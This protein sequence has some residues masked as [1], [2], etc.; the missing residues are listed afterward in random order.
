MTQGIDQLYFQYT[1]YVSRKP[2]AKPQLE[3]EPLINSGSAG[4][5]LVS[6]LVGT[7]DEVEQS[8]GSRDL[9]RAIAAHITGTNAD[10][11][12]TVDSTESPDNI[13]VIWVADIDT[14][15]D[16]YLTVRAQPV[17]NGDEYT[18]QNVSFV[19]NAIDTLADVAEYN[20]IRT[21][22]INHVTLEVVEQTY[23]K[24][25]EV[26]HQKEN[27]LVIEYQNS[28]NSVVE[29]SRKA[30]EPI[31]KNIQRLEKKKA[32]GQAYNTTKLLS[33]QNLLAQEERE[34]RNYI[35]RRQEELQNQ[36]QETKREIELTA[37]LKIQEVQRQYKIA[38]VVIP[39]IPP[40]LVGIFVATRR[41]L[42][43]REGIS[44]ARRLK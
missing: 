29:E 1:G 23:D 31:Q 25:M 22:K 35:T 20:Q 41:R 12:P 4:R 10:Q 28:L 19:L 5:V 6:D 24:A 7:P 38:A 36:R 44:K 9:P 16:M 2:L 32:A 33:L 37:E 15:A 13:N 34:Q 39:P 27:D 3:F 43:E 17:Q 14:L 30:L 18:Y 11:G 8:R 40:L 26:V 21:R 42:R